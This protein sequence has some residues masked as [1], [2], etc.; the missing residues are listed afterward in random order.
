M[1]QIEVDSLPE[2]IAGCENCLAAGSRAAGW[3]R[4][5]LRSSFCPTPAQMQQLLGG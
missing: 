1:D 3:A 2:S 4:D 5:D